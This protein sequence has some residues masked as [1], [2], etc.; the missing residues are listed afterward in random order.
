MVKASLNKTERIKQRKLIGQLF[1]KGRSIRKYPLKLVY[2]KIEAP[3]NEQAL[4]FS[5]TVPKR[6]F[7]KAVHRNLL[8]RRVREA[9]RQEKASLQDRLSF[10]PGQYALMFIYIARE[11]ETYAKIQKSVRKL[12]KTLLD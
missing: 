7:R 5:V 11:I 3:E 12:L 9:Y 4:L 6:S 10:P 2:L 8:K 1:E